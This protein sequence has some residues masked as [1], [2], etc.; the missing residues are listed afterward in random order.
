MSQLLNA[1]KQN[2][3]LFQGE[4]GEEEA[5][6]KTAEENWARE[7]EGDNCFIRPTADSF[8]KKSSWA[9]LRPF[10]RGEIL[11]QEKLKGATLFFSPSEVLCRGR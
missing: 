3:F 8:R 6:E 1:K 4:K 7:R 5:W 10:L 11:L 9:R 2:C